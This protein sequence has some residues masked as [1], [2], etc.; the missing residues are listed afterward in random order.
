MITT[1]ATT[2]NVHLIVETIIAW[3]LGMAFTLNVTLKARRRT[4][5]SVCWSVLSVHV[6]NIITECIVLGE[7]SVGHCVPSRVT[8]YGPVADISASVQTPRFLRSQII[9]IMNLRL[10]ITAWIWRLLVWCTPT[11]VNTSI[12]S[13]CFCER[14]LLS[15]KCV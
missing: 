6:W 13:L 7:M 8:T 12:N 9:K 14:L 2:R 15:R 10:F 3:H 4:T 1:A 5:V 11:I